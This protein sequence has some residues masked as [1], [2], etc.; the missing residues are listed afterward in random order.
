M[1]LGSGLGDPDI[2]LAATL[3]FYGAYGLKKPAALNG[4]QFLTADVLGK[5]LRIERDQAY[6]PTGPGLGIEVNERKV[7]DLMKRSGGD[8]LLR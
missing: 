5:P 7:I 8:K 2:S 6:V 4:P 1:W 3:C